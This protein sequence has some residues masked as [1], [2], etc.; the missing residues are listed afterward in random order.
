MVSPILSQG[1]FYLGDYL[2]RKLLVLCLDERCFIGT[3]CSFDHYGSIVLE[4]AFERNVVENQYCDNPIGLL[5]VRA[6]NI[7]L[8]GELDLSLPQ[9]P[10]HMTSVSLPQ[11]LTAR[12][13]ERESLVLKRT[14][15]KWMEE[16]LEEDM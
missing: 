5:V 13:A 15:K 4:S 1:I 6:E 16:L 12:K 11:I 9:L 2:D 7:I 10:P 3:F 14:L 8:I